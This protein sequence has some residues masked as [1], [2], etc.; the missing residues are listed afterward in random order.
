MSEELTQETTTVEGQETRTFTQEE[1]NAIMA[2]RVGRVHK[3]YADYDE[4]K[5]QAGKYTELME[6][7][8]SDLQKQTERADALQAQLTALQKADD[9][10]KIREKV[11]SESGVPAHL[12]NGEDEEACK[13][14]AEAIKEFAK[15]Q[16]M[17]PNV[18]DKG[19]VITQGTGKTRDQFANWFNATL[20]KE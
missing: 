1:V 13:A 12:L 17:Y 5:E 20:K 19:E 14:Q 4:L 2:E 10:R 6:S 3:K 15:P 18:K 9:I 8:K 7:Q 11:S 16:S